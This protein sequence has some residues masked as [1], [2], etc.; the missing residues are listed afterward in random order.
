MFLVA[1]FLLGED[2]PTNTTPFSIYMLLIYVD[3]WSSWRAGVDGEGILTYPRERLDTNWLW[4]WDS[5]M[6]LQNEKNN[7]TNIKS[8]KTVLN[9]NFL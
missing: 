8:N 1:T 6:F 9:L 2:M 3:L 4:S 5:L 7:V